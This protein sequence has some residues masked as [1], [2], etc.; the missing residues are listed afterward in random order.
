MLFPQLNSVTDDFRRVC[1][2]RE[3]NVA[4]IVVSFRPEMGEQDTREDVEALISSL[5]LDYATVEMTVLQVILTKS[6]P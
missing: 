1:L 3:E 6:N 5:Q 4:L 2:A